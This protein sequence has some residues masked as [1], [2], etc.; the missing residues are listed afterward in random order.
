VSDVQAFDAAVEAD[1]R[2]RVSITVPFDPSALWGKR[3][4]HHVRGTLN[5]HPF[6]G[7]LGVRGGRV[8]LP[9]AKKLRADVGIEPGENVAVTM[10]PAAE[11]SES[12]PPELADLLAED[13]TAKAFFDGLSG[14]YRRQYAEWVAD[15]KQPTTRRHRA[16]QALELLR[17]GRKSR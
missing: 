7:S 14:F 10:A 12:V 13:A 3:Q 6:E 9:L 8:F 1:D 11:R 16:E 17:Q 4:R 2:G 5:G 15:G